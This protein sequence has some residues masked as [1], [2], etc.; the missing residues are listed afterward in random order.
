MRSNS[1][2]ELAHKVFIARFYTQNAGFFL[3]IFV[4]MFGIVQGGLLLRYHYQLIMGILEVPAA[5]LVALGLWSLYLFK[6]MKFVSKTIIA[7]DGFFLRI[8]NE[9]DAQR[10]NPSDRKSTRL[11]SSHM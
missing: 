4:M 6:C 2:S 3:F 10:K 5:L 1:L 9:M 11:N 7:P 8:L